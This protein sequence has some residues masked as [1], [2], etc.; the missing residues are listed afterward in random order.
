MLNNRNKVTMKDVAKYAGV[1]IGTVDRVLNN[2]GYVS[3][4][5]KEVIQKA[6]KDLNYIPNKAASALSRQKKL[7]IA[8]VYPNV[9]KY[10]WAQI[11]A[12]IDKAEKQFGPYGLS[13]FKSYVES[14]SVEEQE[15][16]LTALSKNP[17][18][19]GLA[20]VPVH[21]NKLNNLINEIASKGIPVVTFDSDAPAS[22]RLCHIGEDAV[23]GGRIAGRLL[24]LYMGGKGKAAVLRGQNNLLAIQQR[25]SGFVETI[26][27]EYPDIEIARFY[28]MYDNHEDYNK[29][30]NDI[31][32]RVL[33]GGSDING[34]F[35]ANALVNLVGNAVKEASSPKGLKIVGFDYTEEI[36]SLI[37]ENMI[38]ATISTDLEYEGFSA[39]K[40]LFEAITENRGLES[41]HIIS[42]FDIRIKETI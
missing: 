8:V 36:G 27:S 17:D 1:A 7:N 26:S 31:V 22:K 33:D 5:K 28:D 15:K 10:F 3:D 2:T 29:N 18:I 19:H 32:V 13:I 42:K 23:K 6:I 38:S 25:I 21:S 37:R 12:G 35:V 30:I 9:E 14:Y 16:V 41:D 39:I 11:N 40:T 24:A 20:I 4:K 34:V